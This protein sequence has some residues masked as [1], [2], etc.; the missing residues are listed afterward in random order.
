MS[1]PAPVSALVG[2]IL[3]APFWNTEVAAALTFLTN[4]P[5][6][7]VYQTAPTSLASGTSTAVAFDTELEDD[8]AMHS[9]TSN[10]SRITIATAGL[11]LVTAQVTFDTASSTGSRSVFIRRS[12]SNVATSGG[13]ASSGTHTESCTAPV[14]LTAGQYLQLFA[15]QDSGSAMDARSGS[16]STFLSAR[17]IAA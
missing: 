9:T 6:A 4:P 17:W 7:N 12:G 13:A 2:Q 3:T 5:Y 15:Y 11:Y 14:R 16:A 10:N 1:A 8:T